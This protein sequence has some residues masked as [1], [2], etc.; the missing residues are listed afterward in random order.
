MCNL[1][2][3]YIVEGNKYFKLFDHFHLL[4]S[5]LSIL[6]NKKYIFGIYER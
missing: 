3:K 6:L 1:R 5:F 2:R 4:F